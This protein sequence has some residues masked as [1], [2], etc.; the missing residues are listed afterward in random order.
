MRNTRR[1]SFHGATYLVAIQLPVLYLP[2]A[3]VGVIRLFSR[4]C[5]WL[6]EGPH[7]TV[8]GGR[9]VEV[10]GAAAISGDAISLVVPTTEL[11]FAKAVEA[12][13]CT[14]CVPVRELCD[15]DRQ[16]RRALARWPSASAAPF[17]PVQFLMWEAWSPP[18]SRRKQLQVRRGQHQREWMS[19]PCTHPDTRTRRGEQHHATGAPS[20]RMARLRH[21]RHT[22]H[23][24]RPFPQGPVPPPPPPPLRLLPARRSWTAPSPP[25]PT[26]RPPSMDLRCRQVQLLA[27]LPAAS[28]CTGALQGSPA[29]ESTRIPR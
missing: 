25:C 10:I 2:L 20:L 18:T 19:A 3:T 9:R 11:L 15:S 16:M 27:L 24:H 12:A 21:I 7:P 1:R 13:R 28:R 22:R 6:F 8:D 29:L 14:P 23:A 5:P 17:A 4:A 26:V